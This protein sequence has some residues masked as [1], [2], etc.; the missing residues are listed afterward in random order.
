LPEN[1]QYETVEGISQVVNWVTLPYAIGLLQAYTQKHASNPEQFEFMMPV[2]QRTDLDRAVAGLRNADIVGFSTYV[3]NVQ[4]SLAL[5]QHLKALQPETLIVFGGP[6]VP[7]RAEAFLRQYPFIDLVVHGEGERV[8]LE[9]LEHLHDR[10]WERAPS[11]SYLGLDGVFATNPKAER[12]ANLSAVPSPYLTGVFDT[13]MQAH[14][15]TVYMSL[16]ETK[17]AQTTA[18]P[19][20]TCVPRPFSRT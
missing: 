4:Y 9:I 7:D 8:F 18:K 6:Q 15:D 11:I 20:R 14:P 13:M 5:A 19:R 12:I 3:W 17:R 16:M 10:K 1:R 2:Y